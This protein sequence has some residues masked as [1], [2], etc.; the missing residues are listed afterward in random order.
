MKRLIWTSLIFLVCLQRAISMELKKEDSEGLLLTTT[1]YEQ[2]GTRNDFLS[3]RG[4]EDE[5]DDSENERELSV[6]G[7]SLQSLDNNT[8][9]VQPVAKPKESEGQGKRKKMGKRNNRQKN[10]DKN[11]KKNKLEANPC[12]TTHSEYCINGVCV[13][14]GNLNETTCICNGGYSGERCG[15]QQLSSVSREDSIDATQS[16]LVVIAVVLSLISLTAVL[17]II[18]VHCRSQKRFT[19]LYHGRNEEK[20]KLQEDKS[21]SHIVV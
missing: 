14:Y 5:E 10:K 19:E 16:V 17:I 12:T 18:C 21:N 11:D 15:V 8:V 3:Q 13:H 2:D 1:N 6:P 7:D 9:R 4:F 20:E